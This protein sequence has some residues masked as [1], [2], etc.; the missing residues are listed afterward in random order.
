M[1]II[2]GGGRG[3]GLAIAKA[4]A[5]QGCNLALCAR[6]GEELDSAAQFIQ[7]NYG[8]KVKTCCANV[9]DEQAVNRMI[10]S[11]IESFGRID[12]LVNN[13]GIVGPLGPLEQIESSAWW[14]AIHINLGGAFYCIKAVLPHMNAKKYGRILNMSGGGVFVPAPYMDAYAVTKIAIARLTENLALEL[15]DTGVVVTALSPGGV[16]TKM[17]D[18]M[19]A[20]GKESVSIEIWEGFL[21]R[22]EAGGDPINAPANLAV[23]LATEE[24]SSVNGRLIAAKWDHWDSFKEHKK[25]IEST[26]IYTLRRILPKDRGYNW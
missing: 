5:Q 18:E 10:D 25:E 9:S 6:T 17:F 15:K 11:V 26:D 24:A 13:A 2:T 20:A 1:A 21:K 12:I 4:Y 3:I 19:L 14:N 7:D 23:F 22:K 16:N 8:T